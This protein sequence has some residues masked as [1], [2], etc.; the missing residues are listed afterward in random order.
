[1]AV[2]H[3]V[4]TRLVAMNAGYIGRDYAIWPDDLEL[5]LEQN[6][7]KLFF[8]KAD[9]AVGMS[10]LSAL[11]PDGFSEYHK[12]LAPGRDFFTYLVP[13]ADSSKFLK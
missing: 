6:G 1:V 3:W 8:V 2:A 11:Y 10:R 4:D 7:A 5:T 13:P 9:D 12:G